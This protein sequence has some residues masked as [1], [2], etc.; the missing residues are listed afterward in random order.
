[1]NWDLLESKLK[2]MDG[3]FKSGF[4][5]NIIVMTLHRIENLSEDLATAIFN[6]LKAVQANQ[7]VENK[8]TLEQN[9]DEQKE[10]SNG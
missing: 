3:M 10:V 9:K 5:L 4:P 8:E 2:I 7:P 1:M 6:V